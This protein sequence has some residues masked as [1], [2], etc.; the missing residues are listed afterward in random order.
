MRRRLEL[1]NTIDERFYIQVVTKT[2][3][4][5]SLVHGYEGEKSISYDE[6]DEVIGNETLII[7]D[8]ENSP[9]ETVFHHID[10]MSNSQLYEFIL[11][12]IEEILAQD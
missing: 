3:I 4:N 9:H 12:Q 1:L 6:T 2:R 8:L 5:C 10:Y 7:K 11:Q